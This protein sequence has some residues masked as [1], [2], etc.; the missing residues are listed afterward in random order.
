[1]TSLHMRVCMFAW[2]L[3]ACLDQPLTVSHARL[4]FCMFRV[5]R[6]FK[7]GWRIAVKDVANLLNGDNKTARGL[8]YSVSKAIEVTAWQSVNVVCLCCLTCGSF[9]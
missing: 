9:H 4:L 5:I 6:Q 8:T 2:C 1:M 3:L 7:K